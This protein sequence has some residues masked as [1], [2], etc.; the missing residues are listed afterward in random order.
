VAVGAIAVIAVLAGGCRPGQLAD[1]LLNGGFLPI[2]AA[3]WQ[4]LAPRVG[5]DP[6]LPLVERLSTAEGLDVNVTAPVT[7]GDLSAR[8]KG[9]FGDPNHFGVYLMV[10]AVIALA[11]LVV[12]L[13]RRD[14]P[15]TVACVGASTAFGLALLSTYSRTAWLGAAVAAVVFAALLWGIVPWGRPS[16]R[17]VV[18][19]S[20]A[21]AVVLALCVPLISNIVERLAPSSPVNVGSNRTHE[22]TARA[23]FDEFQANPLLGAGPGS[24][25][26]LLNQGPRTSAAHS[27]YLTVAA[28][29]GLVG[30][31]LVFAAAGTTL[32][33]FFAESRA[34]PERRRV[35]AAGAAAAYAG[36]LT[37]NI[38][39]DLWWDDFHWVLVGTAACG[40]QAV[41]RES[42][43]AADQPAS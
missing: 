36:F 22:A 1:A 42:V 40:V 2:A 18:A 6:T 33:R 14:R 32:L 17:T 31:L 35:L 24:L 30:L 4:A 28:E 8:T 12:A 15:A 23:A 7:V 34:G 25:G 37:A 9:T 20:V 19:A 39:Y 3:A 21:G 5:A 38:T 43:A 11:V 16:R 13:R 10:L 26:A 29:L 27:T 41:R